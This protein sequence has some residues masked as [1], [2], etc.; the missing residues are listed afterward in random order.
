MTENSKNILE[1]P[2]N[3]A[4]D[5]RSGATPVQASQYLLFLLSE[6]AGENGHHKFEQI[7]FQLARRRIYSNVIPST[8]PV[9]AGGDQGA[10][11]ETY[12][13]GKVLPFGPRSPFFARVTEEKV[14]FACSIEKNVSKKIKEDL[15]AA[16]VF[17]EKVERVVFMSCWNV[18]VGKRHKLK[19][20]ALKTHGLPLEIFDAR[21]ISELLVDPELFWVAQHYLSVPSE[22]TLAVPKSGHEWYEKILKLSVDPGCLVMSDFFRLKQAVRFAT[23]N[24]GYKSDLPSLLMKIRD[25]RGYPSEEIQRRAFYEDFVASLRGLEMVRGIW[26]AS[27]GVYCCRCYE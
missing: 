13:T 3:P 25:F 21:A 22:F 2:P 1:T 26:G 4:G 15:V 9:S 27:G 16:T 19:E 17:P 23:R 5:M 24:S 7:C 20:Y 8:G 18:P 12:R 11:F 14:V 6:L 10:D